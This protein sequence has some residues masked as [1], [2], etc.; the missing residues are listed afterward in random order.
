MDRSVLLELA[1]NIKSES[2]GDLTAAKIC[3]VFK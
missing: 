3:R 1:H 2:E